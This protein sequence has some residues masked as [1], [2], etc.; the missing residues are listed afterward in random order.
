MQGKITI[1]QNNKNQIIK[2]KINIELNQTILYHIRKTD[3]DIETNCSGIGKCLKDRIFITKGFT[4]L[5]PKTEIEKKHN[6]AKNERLACLTKITSDEKDIEIIINKKKKLSII[7][8]DLDYTSRDDQILN[9]K[10]NNKELGLAIDIGTTT[11]V[12]QVVELKTNKIIT[13]LS[14]EN[15]QVNYGADVIS[16]IQFTKEKDDGLEILHNLIINQINNML[17]EINK[18]FDQKITD[19]IKKAV[20]VGNSCMRDIFLNID[21]KTLGAIPFSSIAPQEHTKKAKDLSIILND[22]TKLYFPPLIAHHIGSDILSG[23]ICTEIYKSNDICMI[24]DLG[25]NG[26]IV[27]GNK[28]KLLVASAAT[29]SAFEGYNTRSGSPAFDGA[30]SN[31]FLKNNELAY[32][33][34]NNQKAESICG[35]GYIDLLAV[36]Y[37]LG[38]LNKKAKLDN[39]E[40]IINEDIKLTQKDVFELITAKASL[41]LTQDMLI[42]YFGITIDDIKKVYLAGG[43]GNYINADNAKKIGLYPD[44]D[45]CKFRKIGNSAITGARYL[46]Q[47]SKRNQIEKIFEIIEHKNPNIVEG[48]NYSLLLAERMYF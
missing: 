23:I 32:S 10:H 47:E 43:F 7:T 46:L 17:N 6:F 8:D 36:L 33:T 40:Y 35:S 45:N 19:S 34:I 28:D 2:K 31:F 41:R 38:V 9:Y 20:I 39:K 30:I 44:I 15:I 1:I 5:S 42:N 22:D 12:M 4:S 37:D 48:N 14:S 3:L 16:R 29:G 27:I 18:Q 25:T 13:T 24:V 11:I 26:E 21:V